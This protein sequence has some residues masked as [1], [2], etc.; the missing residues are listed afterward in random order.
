MLNAFRH[1]RT[2][3]S[4][5]LHDVR[6]VWC[7]QR[8]SAS[9]N[10]HTARTSPRRQRLTVLN[11]FRHQ[12]TNDTAP[13]SACRSSMVCSTPFGINERTTRM[14]HRSRRRRISAQRLSASTNEPLTRWMYRRSLDRSAQR[15]SASTNEPP[16]ITRRLKVL[17]VLNA[18]RH[19]RTNDTLSRDADAR[20]VRRCSTPFGINERTP[21]TQAAVGPLHLDVLNAF[22]HQR[23]NAPR[24]SANARLL[25]EVLNAFRHQRTNDAALGCRTRRKSCS[26]QRLSASTNERTRSRLDARLSTIDC[27]QRL[28]ASTNEPRR[29]P[30]ASPNG[31][32]CAQRLSASTNE[33]RIDGGPWPAIRHVLNAFRHQ[34]TNHSTTCHRATSLLIVLN[35]FRHQR[36]NHSMSQLAIVETS[37]VLNAFRHQR[38]NHSRRSAGDAAI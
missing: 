24:L 15:L 26:A 13:A 22:R 6:A 7:A 10:E 5:T 2:N 32:R 36:T 25:H 30:T 35:A 20:P 9:T 23:T 31:R 19:Q 21:S 14:F 4:L 3:H 1:Q 27:A 8:L 38:T 37:H 34:R 29:D 11:A 16:R 33:P 12:R 28:S 18:F 17:Q